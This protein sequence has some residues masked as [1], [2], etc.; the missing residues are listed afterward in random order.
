MLTLTHDLFSEKLRN[1]FDFPP[2][3][4]IGVLQASP[5]YY[6]LIGQLILEVTSQ[7]YPINRSSLSC[8]DLDLLCLT[9]SKQPNTHNHAQI[10]LLDQQLCQD[11]NHQ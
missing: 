1:S 8:L 3:D 10:H 5:D 7:V 9:P 2:K 6:V 11:N 4:M